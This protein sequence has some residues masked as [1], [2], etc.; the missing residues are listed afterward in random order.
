LDVGV[1]RQF[2]IIFE[3]QAIRVVVFR[4]PGEG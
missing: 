1:G 2:D 4:V 3:Q